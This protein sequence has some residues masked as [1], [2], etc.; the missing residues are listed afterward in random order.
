[1]DAF[2]ASVEMLDDPSLQG[3][4]LIVGGSPQSRG[5]VC[6]ASYEARTFGVRSAMSCA[7][8]ARLCPQGIFVKPRFERYYEIS[9]QI[10]AIMLR[11]SQ[12]LEP[13]SLDEAYLDVTDNALGLYATEI[14]R[15]IRA[16]IRSELHLSASAGVAPNKM[17]AKIASDLKKPDGLSV[18]LPEQVATFVKTLPLK[19]IHGV[20][21]VSAKHLEDQGFRVCGDVTTLS[22]DE[23]LNRLGETYGAWIFMRSQG[24]DDRRVETSRERKSYGH[25]TTF[26]KDLHGI[27]DMHA[28]LKAL[29]ADLADT[30]KDEG[31][32]GRSVT[33][34]AR[35]PDFKT[36]TRALTLHEATDDEALLAGTAF[37]LLGKT[38]ARSR[39][40]RLLG[41]SVTKLEG[42][43]YEN[44]DDVTATLQAPRQRS[45]FGD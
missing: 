42:L 6:T 40:V 30:L 9:R 25:E 33:L 5:V 31:A 8:A 19:R 14:A 22:R 11:Y 32:K 2:Y 15:R 21:Q 29:A 10:R 35:Y 12:T 38:D 36:V 4:P 43:V 13:L 39:G 37:G 23:V 16:D 3:K 18:I 26:A 41:I 28:T 1:M 17:L 34:K 20:G 7:K 27:D 24:L 44:Q 45:L